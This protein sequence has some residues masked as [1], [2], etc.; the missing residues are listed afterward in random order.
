MTM[1]GMPRRQFVR[2][3]GTAGATG[4]LGLAGADR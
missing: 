1:G 3:S 4:L 2:L